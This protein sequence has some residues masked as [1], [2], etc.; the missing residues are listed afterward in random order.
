MLSKGR[1]AIFYGGAGHT[2]NVPW[3]RYDAETKTCS[4]SASAGQLLKELRA[5]KVFSLKL[6]SPNTYH[7]WYP[8]ADPKG[9]ER[10]LG[11]RLDEAFHELGDRPIAFDVAASPLAPL[12]RKD[13]FR[14]DVGKERAER[15]P[16]PVE[17]EANR[18]LALEFEG[19]VF[20]GPLSRYTGATVLPPSYFDE[21]FLRRVAARTDGKVKTPRQ[22]Y[23]EIKKGRPMLEASIN[24]LL[25]E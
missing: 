12:R 16:C 23:E 5:E 7:A 8:T 25:G 19:I 6:W 22:A 13:F 9:W 21:A 14:I 4:L 24:Q 17:V 15:P 18:P 2:R 11:G 10:F 3:S 1:K 20:L